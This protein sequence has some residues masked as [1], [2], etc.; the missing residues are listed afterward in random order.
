MMCL[1]TYVK[2]NWGLLFCDPCRFLAGL[3]LPPYTFVPA[4]PYCLYLLSCIR[5]TLWT[6]SMICVKLW[7]A[8]LN[9]VFILTVIPPQGLFDHFSY[10]F[11]SHFSDSLVYMGCP[12]DDP[13]S[14]SIG[15]CLWVQWKANRLLKRCDESPCCCPHCESAFDSWP[16]GMSHSGYAVVEG[17]VLELFMQPWEVFLS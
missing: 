15:P 2:L 6:L 16:L 8:M 5:L 11:L 7:R 13:G 14:Q 3:Q 12:L 1:Y 4:L 10:F 17:G 9:K